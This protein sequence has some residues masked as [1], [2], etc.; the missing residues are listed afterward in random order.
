MPEDYWSIKKVI[1]M[2]IATL[3]SEYW[4]SINQNLSVNKSLTLVH[5]L[6][7]EGEYVARSLLC[8]PLGFLPILHLCLWVSKGAPIEGRFDVRE[9]ACWVT[10]L[11]VATLHYNQVGGVSGGW[12]YYSPLN[13]LISASNA[14]ELVSQSFTPYSHE[15]IKFGW[16]GRISSS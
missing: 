4:A 6:C 9:E 11:S 7:L 16:L 13:L 1:N 5:R 12:D 8:I 2:S 10:P 15:D 14:A 3:S